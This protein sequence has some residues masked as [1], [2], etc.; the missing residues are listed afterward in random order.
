VCVCVCVRILTIITKIKRLA[1]SGN[2]LKDRGTA[3]REDTHPPTPPTTP[4]QLQNTAGS[5]TGRFAD[6]KSE[7]DHDRRLPQQS[8]QAAPEGRRSSVGG[9]HIYL[10]P[11]YY[12]VKPQPVALSKQRLERDAELEASLYLTHPFKS[13]QA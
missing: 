6:L 12:D 4:T 7:S 13:D 11:V 5:L 10:L 9:Y 1:K 8:T 2:S 3:I